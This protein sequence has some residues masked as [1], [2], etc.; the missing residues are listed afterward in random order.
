[1][2]H[3]MDAWAQRTR[4]KHYWALAQKKLGCAIT[5]A[6][7]EPCCVFCLAVGIFLSIFCWTL[8]WGKTLIEE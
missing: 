1:M 3:K 8:W 2:F 6:Q 4:A 7:N 5:H